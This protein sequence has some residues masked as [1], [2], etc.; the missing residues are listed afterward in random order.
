MA[1]EIQAKHT[2]GKNAYTLI[3]AA[4]GADVGKIRD[5]GGASFE[6]YVTANLDNYDT[7]LTEQGTA[8]G[9][10][11]GT[12]Q[13]SIPAGLYWLLTYERAGGSP[14]EGDTP[15]GEETVTW[16]GTA[17]VDLT[18]LLVA[19]ST[20]GK[21]DVN[22]EMVDVMDTD[23]IP[24]LSQGQPPT[25]PTHRQSSMLLYMLIR[26]KKTAS[27]TLEEIFNNAGTVITK[28]TLSDAAGVFTR[29]KLVSGP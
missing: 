25:T 14:A 17:F 24:E 15:V 21:S 12:F 2:T 26:N 23:T 6:T 13:A 4:N 28:G 29:A 10:Y 9:I 19:L 8:S 16:N 22:G 5:L 3:L 1:N 11:L 18:G 20:T 27:P 7:V